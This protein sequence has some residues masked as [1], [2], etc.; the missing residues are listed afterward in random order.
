MI[1]YGSEE[2]GQFLLSCPDYMRVSPAAAQ[3]REAAW[4]LM[5]SRGGLAQRYPHPPLALLLA[6][7]AYAGGYNRGVVD[8]M[9]DKRGG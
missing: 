4:W 6:A 8:K 7:Q 5:D 9:K 3:A 2:D 1:L